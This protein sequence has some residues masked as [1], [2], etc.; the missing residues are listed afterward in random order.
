MLLSNPRVFDGSKFRRVKSLLIDSS[1]KHSI[2]IRESAETFNWTS[3]K[4]ID[5]SGLTVT[6][7]FHD[8]HTHLLSYAAN[9]GTYGIEL[10]N[11]SRDSL[12]MLLRKA[13]ASQPNSALVR[14]SGICLLYT[15]DAATIYSV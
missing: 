15:S 14:V 3:I 1:E 7:P 6:P 4:E 10:D 2:Q 5:A 8:T 13:A 9:F 11:P 12:I